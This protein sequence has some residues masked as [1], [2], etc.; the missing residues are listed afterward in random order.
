M[1]WWSFRRSLYL[2]LHLTLHHLL[3]TESGK[4]TRYYDYILTILQMRDHFLKYG[5]MSKRRDYDQDII[6]SIH[7]LR[8]IHCSSS[9]LATKAHISLK[10]HFL[11]FPDLQVIF[12]CF[13]RF[14]H[15]HMIFLSGDLG[16]PGSCSISTISSMLLWSIPSNSRVVPPLM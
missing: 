8:Y 16:T 1:A 5:F 2:S 12:C 11:F 7:G 14:P 13:K 9:K 3:K 6:R 15:Y 4:V 10:E